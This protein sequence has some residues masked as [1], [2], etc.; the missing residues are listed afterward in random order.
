M[1]S[2]PALVQ[3]HGGERTAAKCGILQP[4][5]V[6]ESLTSPWHS[7]VQWL[8]PGDQRG[9]GHRHGAGGNGEAVVCAF[10]E[11]LSQLA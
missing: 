4:G 9:L 3:P 10:G 6:K 11:V 1:P 8:R 5:G 7:G 2:I